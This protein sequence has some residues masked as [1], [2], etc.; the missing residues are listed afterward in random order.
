MKNMI[1]ELLSPAGSY[2]SFEAAIGAG[3]DAVYVGGPAFGGHFPER[4]L[5]SVHDSLWKWEM[6]FML[7][8]STGVCR[9]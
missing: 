6:H 3:A 7:I 5:F 9:I 2:E 1:T 4:K 8:S